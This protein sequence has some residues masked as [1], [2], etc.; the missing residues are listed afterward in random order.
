MINDCIIIMKNNGLV[1]SPVLWCRQNSVN[2]YWWFT[3]KNTV[4]DWQIL[5]S[6][7]PLKASIKIRWFTESEKVGKRGE[8]GNAWFEE[9]FFCLIKMAS[10][11]D[12]KYKLYN[13]TDKYFVYKWEIQCVCKMIIFFYFYDRLV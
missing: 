12:P 8:I 11:A 6:G 7:F 1:T 9:W 5:A 4:C 13:Y 10:G 3:S 2:K